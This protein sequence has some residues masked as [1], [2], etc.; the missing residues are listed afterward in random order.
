MEG[1]QKGKLGIAWKRA[2]GDR[3]GEYSD[4]GDKVLRVAYQGAAKP[5][6]AALAV[7]RV[8]QHDGLEQQRPGLRE[9]S[10]SCAREWYSTV[11]AGWCRFNRILL[12][13][14]LESHTK[15]MH[16]GPRRIGK[17]IVRVIKRSWGS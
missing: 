1:K 15:L 16:A 14:G 13:D 8:A 3:V 11:Q 9:P 6:M 7:H 2:E 10:L 5:K 4:D 12:Q 17:E